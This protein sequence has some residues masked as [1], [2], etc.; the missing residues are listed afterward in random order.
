VAFLTSGD[1]SAV[2]PVLEAMWGEPVGQAQQLD[3]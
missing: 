1:P 3:V 2:R